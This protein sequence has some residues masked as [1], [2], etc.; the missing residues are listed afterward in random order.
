MVGRVA[1]DSV[2][3]NKEIGGFGCMAEYGCT[4]E[5]VMDDLG[6]LAFVYIAE[7]EGFCVAYIQN[8]GLTE[9][10]LWDVIVLLVCFSIVVHYGCP[11]AVST[12]QWRILFL[13]VSVTV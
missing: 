5:I 13:Y 2:P 11:H 9:V 6:N 10:E 4:E 7:K 8:G 3:D 1:V 12:H